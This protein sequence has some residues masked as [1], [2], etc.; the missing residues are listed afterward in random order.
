MA[1]QDT[2]VIIKP[3]AVQRTLTTKIR[4]YIHNGGLKIVKEEWVTP[5]GALMRHHYPDDMAMSLGLKSK[6]AGENLRNNT[7]ILAMG[8]KILFALRNYMMSGPV[9][10][11]LVRGENAIKRMRD[12]A[13]Y[14]DPSAAQKGTIRGDLGQDSILKANREGRAVR[15]LIHASGTEE[16]AKNEIEL[17]FAK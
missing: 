6:K 9:L 15:N 10:V 17:W 4:E 16:E 13:G 2:L 8:E 14:T 1:M 12:I 3:D 11:M 5:S 7:E